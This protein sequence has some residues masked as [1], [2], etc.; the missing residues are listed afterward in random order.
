MHGLWALVQEKHPEIELI[1]DYGEG[2]GYLDRLAVERMRRLLTYIYLKRPGRWSLQ[3]TAG[4]SRRY[5]KNW[6]TVYP[7]D[8]R[9]P[10]TSGLALSARARVLVRRKGLDT[11]PNTLED[12]IQPARAGT[13]AGGIIA[14][15]SSF[16]GGVTAY[17][18]DHGEE[19]ARVWLGGLQT[20]SKGN[21]HPKHTP[22]V[23]AVAEGQADVALVNHYYFYRNILGKTVDPDMT[24]EDIQGKL[25]AA[26]IEIVSSRHRQQGCRLERVWRWLDKGRPKP[27]GCSRCSRRFALR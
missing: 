16:V 18:A 9:V 27:Q 14:T 11:P 22:A 19:K 1:V 21:V 17:I 24:V 12:L 7:H 6:Q 3:Q 10:T 23:A 4:C 25:D 15:N 8:F 2:L 26:P 13:V 5:R 20:N